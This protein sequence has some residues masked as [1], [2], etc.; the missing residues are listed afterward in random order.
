[1]LDG[2]FKATIHNYDLMRQKA[3]TMIWEKK[4]QLDT[5]YMSTEVF[6]PDDRQTW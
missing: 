1:M 6:L 4:N 2:L 3:K 5:I